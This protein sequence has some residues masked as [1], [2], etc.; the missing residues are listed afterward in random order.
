MLNIHTGH[1][2]DYLTDAVATGREGYYTGAVAA[3]EPVGLWYGKGAAALGL[4]GEV[5][6][7]MMKALYT[8]GL[9]PTD[10]ATSSRETWHEAARFGNAPKSYKK[11]DEIYAGLLEAHPGAG[12]E[13]RAE[14]RAQAGRSARQSVAFYDVVLSAPKSMTVAWVAYERA[15]NDARAAGDHEAAAVWAGKAATVEEALLVGHRAVLDFF[16]EKAGYGRAGRHGGS[17]GKWLDAHELVAAQFLQHDSRDKDPQLHVHGPILNKAECSDGVVRALDGT[18]ITQW[19]DAA[20]AIGARVA[21]AYAAEQLGWR[22]E[23]RPDGAA[24]EVVGV[25]TESTG[26]FSKR[27]KAI[28]PV[29]EALVARFKAE[30]GREPSPAERTKLNEQATLSTR[31]GK[32]Y[33]GETREGQI[34]RWAVEHAEQ[35]GVEL[36]EVAIGLDAQRPGEATTWSERDVLMRAIGTMENARG[37]WDRSNLMRAIDEALPGQLGIPHGEIPRLLE[38]LA[39]KAEELVQLVRDNPDLPDMGEDYRRA[40]GSNV[41][42]KPHRQRFATDTQLLGEAE[43]RAAAVRRDA[44]AWSDTDA[45]EVLARFTRSGRELGVD[46]AAALRGILTS[47][48]SVEVLAAPAGTGKSF[49]VGTLAETWPLTGRGVPPGGPDE[50]TSYPE[51]TG[52]PNLTGDPAEPLEGP[53]VFGVAYGQRQADVLAEEGVTARNIRRWLDGQARLD[54]GTG[55]GG[56]E[57]FRLRSGDLLVVDE[58][59]AADTASLVAIHRRC[60][61][62]GAKL[63]LVGDSKQLAAVGPGGAL[64]DIAE[65]GVRYELAEV[66]RFRNDWEGPASLRLR[67]GDTSVV[68]EYAKQGRLVDGGTVEQAESAAARTWLADTVAG[69]EALLVVGSNEAAARVSA[70]LRSELVRLGRVEESGVPL[71]MQGTVAGV[72]D[73]VQARKNAW[74][75]EGF[76]GNSEAPINRTT[77]R[78][79]G[80]HADG[81]GLTVARVTGRDAEGVEQLGEPL[82]LPGSYVRDRVTLA[83]AS[84]VHAAHGRTVDAGYSVLGP[85]TDP[86]AAYTAHTRGRDTNVAFV[87]TRKVST[88]A[89]TGETLTFHERTAADALAELIVPRDEGHNRTALAEA[90]QAAEQARSTSAVVDPMLSVIADVTAGRTER[91]LDQLAATGALPERHRVA[92]A[93]DEARGALDGLLRSAELAGHDPAAVLAAA[94]TDRS[95]DKSASVAQV[96]H[97]RIRAALKDRLTPTVEGFGDLLPRDLPDSVRPALEQLAAAADARATELGAQQAAQPSQWVQEALGPVPPADDPRR[98]GWERKAGMAASYR[99]FADHADEADPLGAAPPAGLAEKHALFR[100][101]HT[102]LDLPDAGADQ[103]AMSEGLLRAQVA[104]WEREQT[105]A[106]RFVADELDATREALR[107]EQDNATLWAARAAVEPDRLERDQLTAAATA[108]QARAEQLAEQVEELR[109]ADDARSMWL[110]ET[111]ATRDKAESARVALGLRGLDLDHPGDR[112]TAQEWIDA[113]TTTKLAAD[114]ERVITEHDIDPAALDTDAQ[115]ADLDD[116]PVAEQAADDQPADDDAPHEQDADSAPADEVAE[117]DEP[118]P[119]DLPA[120]AEQTATPEPT[121]AAEA[122]QDQEPAD[123]PIDDRTVDDQAPDDVPVDE[124]PLHDEPPAPD[125]D[126]PPVQVPDEVGPAP[127]DIRDSSTPEPSE[128]IDP[129]ERRRV[130][131]RDRTAADVAR[132]RLAVEEIEQRRA[133]EAAA[134]EAT[135]TRPDDDED[136][137]RAELARRADQCDEHTDT[138][139]DTTEQDITRER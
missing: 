61:D 130:P 47:G 53:R 70:Q 37:T 41:H 93:A 134:D 76:A 11:A 17:G 113:D 122:A 123:Q 29:A 16:A 62:K 137:H 109:I 83:Y 71:G 49:L 15:A 36:G 8:H 107:T 84:T 89:E 77:Y 74:H 40:D 119:T 73:L 95:L 58:A 44:P 116:Q 50:P 78:V 103:E 48:A 26:L 14:L 51:P 10:P 34:A 13:A 52:D 4:V 67:D 45:G 38:G 135:Q 46:Q 124:E 90:E 66:R 42:A 63:L 118:E 60:Q 55:D 30:T 82:Q 101:A 3:G 87:V 35:L 33:G 32:E 138:T 25:D 131:A 20:S 5:D 64:A 12:P 114:A 121:E 1:D 129:T 88:E 120:A 98:A 7:E 54:H 127:V 2:T 59:G 23:T 22:W 132:A 106:P 68:A 27:T 31:R 115:G 126:L 92:L 79:A 117:Q 9:D 102:G 18:L 139:E 136:A 104:A 69:R 91:W 19:K 125:G 81:A 99:E 86:A 108:A 39:A 105:W 43:L 21:Q 80:T 75:L 97:F 72:G 85:G 112:V 56:D 133:A 94:V 110:I 65:R 111:A 6:A 57:A 100:A 24:R 128:R 96:V 28:G